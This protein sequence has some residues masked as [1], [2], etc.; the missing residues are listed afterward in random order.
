MLFSPLLESFPLSEVGSM[1]FFRC[2]VSFVSSS[3][4]SSFPLLL[5]LG[6]KVQHAF[7][8]GFLLGKGVGSLG[9]QELAVEGP[10]TVTAFSGASFSGGQNHRPSGAPREAVKGTQR[11]DQEK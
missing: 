9:V 11:G 2:S 4:S 6:L 10:G 3:S 5:L 1:C 7:Y 8:D